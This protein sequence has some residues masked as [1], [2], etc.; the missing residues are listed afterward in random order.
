MKIVFVSDAYPTKKNISFGIFPYYLYLELTK[1]VKI[2]PVFSKGRFVYQ[3]PFIFLKAL[4]SVLKNKPDVVV[5]ITGN[6]TGFVAVLVGKLTKT[7]S[8]IYLRGS[9]L[10]TFP[11]KSSFNM[12]LMKFTVK[13][14]SC[15]ITAGR[16]LM[17]S[18]IRFGAR[19]EKCGYIYTG[20][21][22]ER[23]KKNMSKSKLRNLLGLPKDKTIL[24][25]VGNVIKDKGIQDIIDALYKIN[26]NQYIFVII[27]SG[28]DIKEMRKRSKMLGNKI[29]FLGQKKY[30]DIAKYYNASDI[31][32]SASHAEGTPNTMFEAMG[33]GLAIIYSKVGEIQYIV[34]G[35]NAI[36]IRHK[37]INQIK[38]AIEKLLNDK[39]L[40][41]Q[42]SKNNLK[43]IKKYKRE[44]A[45]KLFLNILKRVV[46]L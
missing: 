27:G 42:M 29:F 39:K 25:Y 20:I 19:K 13:N 17:E 14:A 34:S 44:D 45:P 24:L 28:K 32:I 3:F 35:K 15:I 4:F 9:D 33:A 5:G 22:L 18:T 6:T 38:N 46:K 21:H 11:Y 2:Y 10:N 37:N 1:V 40:R 12:K 43:D 7:K 41:K 23:F 16:K 30:T 26:N 36:L 31:F 8:A